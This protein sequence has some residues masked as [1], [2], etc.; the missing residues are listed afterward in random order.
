[1]YEK[2]EPKAPS[3]ENIYSLKK[4]F[5]KHHSRSL[6]ICWSQ[7]CSVWDMRQNG[8]KELKLCLRSLH[9]FYSKALFMWRM[10][11]KGLCGEHICSEKRN[12]CM[13]RYDLDF[14]DHCT[15]FDHRL[16]VCEVW[17]AF[18]QGE[19]RYAPGKN[20]SYKSAFTFTF[21]LET[22]FKVMHILNPRAL[23]GW[24]ISQIGP[25]GD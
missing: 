9:T 21:D 19:R 18:D 8:I 5:Y 15:P 2:N 1:M 7:E 4:G 14:Y 3:G 11:Q 24:S 12:F 23:C 16:F 13:V 22:W 25:R 10:S 6:Q 17:A 20:L